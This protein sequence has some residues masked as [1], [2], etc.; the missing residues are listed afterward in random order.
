MQFKTH[1]E[2]R[3]IQFSGQLVR[4]HNRLGM[5]DLSKSDDEYLGLTL[6]C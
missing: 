4:S 2:G 1:V 5:R 3:T 6:I